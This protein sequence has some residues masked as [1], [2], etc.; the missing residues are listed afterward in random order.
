LPENPALLIFHPPEE[1]IPEWVER[2]FVRKAI[3]N[4]LV[5]FVRFEPEFI[6][7]GEEEQAEEQKDDDK[8]E[9]GLH[10]PFLPQR[11]LRA[12]RRKSLYDKSHYHKQ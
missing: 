3:I 8:S 12:P 10:V 5:V 1:E 7:V 2:R 4:G 11:R 6:G 9:R